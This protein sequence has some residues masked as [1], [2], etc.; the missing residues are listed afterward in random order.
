MEVFVNAPVAENSATVLVSEKANPSKMAIG[1]ERDA[2]NHPGSESCDA[3]IA[4]LLIFD[5][6]HTDAEMAEIFNFL[7]R[8]YAFVAGQ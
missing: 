6:A 3:E 7:S 5:T 2:T 1:Q 8:K 4:R